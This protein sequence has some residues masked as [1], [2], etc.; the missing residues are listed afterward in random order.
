M[1][2]KQWEFLSIILSSLALLYLLFINVL[3]K[4]FIVH[5]W[6]VVAIDLFVKIIIEV[7]IIQKEE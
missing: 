6:I 2:K 1:D 3:T 7:I 5:D 4:V